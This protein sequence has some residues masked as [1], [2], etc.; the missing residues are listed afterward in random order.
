MFPIVGFLA[1]QIL[2][3]VR[4]QIEAKKILSLV[5]IITN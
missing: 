2:N 3:I 4:F 5:D 1:C